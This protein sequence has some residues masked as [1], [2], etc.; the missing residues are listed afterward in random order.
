MTPGRGGQEG[1]TPIRIEGSGF[2]EHGPPVV[3]VGERA[4]KGVVVESDRLITA[5][6]PQTENPRP[7]DVTVRFMDGTEIVIEE[8]FTYEAREGIVLQ[9]RIGL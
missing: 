9:P 2:A 8:A 5:L 6:T 1:G 4:A 7:V 3:Y